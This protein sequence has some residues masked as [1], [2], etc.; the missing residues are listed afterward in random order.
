M[1]KIRRSRDRLIFNM[2][3]PIPGKDG[4]YIESSGFAQNKINLLF[5]SVHPLPL[6]N[7][8][9]ENNDQTR[10]HLTLPEP[11]FTKLSDAIWRHRDPLDKLYSTICR[12][13]KQ[14]FVYMICTES[15]N[16]S[17]W[18]GCNLWN[19]FPNM[20]DYLMDFGWVSLFH[21]AGIRLYNKTDISLSR[22][23]SRL[24]SLTRWSRKKFQSTWS[25]WYVYYF[26][27]HWWTWPSVWVRTTVCI[28][29]WFW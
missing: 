15:K 18:R 24:S 4:I 7:P 9:I 5:G 6:V 8:S 17:N 12:L 3:I 26:W 1:L 21:A 14:F 10:W 27:W 13:L 11:M 25:K 28:W 29:H 23:G 2:G 16:I 19:R 22:T 20:I